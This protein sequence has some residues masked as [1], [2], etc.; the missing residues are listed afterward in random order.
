MVRARAS[1]QCGPGSIPGPGVIHWFF[2]GSPVFLPPQKPTL[3]NFNLIRNSGRRSTAN[4]HYIQ[5][6]RSLQ[7]SACSRRVATSGKSCFLDD[8]VNIWLW[9]AV[10]KG[11]DFHNYKHS[12]HL[13]SLLTVLSRKQTLLVITLPHL[14]RANLNL[15][16]QLTIV[17][18]GVMYFQQIL[19]QRNGFRPVMASTS[20]LNLSTPLWRF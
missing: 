15:F 20:A 6:E 7:P 2:S 3:L 16:S 19:N 13:V 10:T 8:Y 9:I 11:G 4:Y 18:T 17:H 14:H 1:Q 12:P 5:L